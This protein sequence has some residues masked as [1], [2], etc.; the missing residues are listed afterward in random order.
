MSQKFKFDPRSYRERLTKFDSSL[1][2]LMREKCPSPDLNSSL[3]KY[4]MNLMHSD[5]D[6]RPDRVSCIVPPVRLADI[7][8]LGAN[9][10][11]ELTPIKNKTFVFDVAGSPYRQGN[12]LV[13]PTYSAL[14]DENRTAYVIPVINPKFSEAFSNQPI[15]V[16]P[17]TLR[18]S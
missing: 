14:E 11:D 15:F 2:A 13:I 4:W 7:A 6:L 1:R 8:I 17:I 3:N 5:N 12:D 10:D 16:Y 9:V 18:V